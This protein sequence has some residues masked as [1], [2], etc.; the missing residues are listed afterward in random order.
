MRVG[1]WNISLSQIADNLSGFASMTQIGG[2]GLAL[3][4]PLF[5]APMMNSAMLKGIGNALQGNAVLFLEQMSGEFFDKGAYVRANKLFGK[6]LKESF[7]DMN[8]NT[9][10]T[11]SGQLFDYF[12]PM[13]GDFLDKLGNKV[14]STM[15]GKLWFKD[16]WFANQYAGEFQIASVTMIMML[17]SYKLIDGKFMAKDDF[18]IKKEKEAKRK[19]TIIEREKLTKEFNDN[20]ESLYQAFELKDG[21]LQPKE[22]YAKII[23][24]NSKAMFAVKDRMQGIS[25][26]I[27]GQYGSTDKSAIERH[28][29]GRLLLLYKKFFPSAM[30]ARFGSAYADQQVYGV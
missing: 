29:G 12:E 13:Q 16:I 10:T 9:R 15:A 18:L 17:E 1:N 8:K 25:K 23:N 30:R 7:S 3:I 20:K 28:F 26:A 4:N 19:L 11:L 24:L 6:H 2:G 21:K 27:Q 5:G 14:T 22:K